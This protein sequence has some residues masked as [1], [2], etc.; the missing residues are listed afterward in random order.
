MPGS[1]NANGSATPGSSADDGTAGAAD[2]SANAPEAPP[3][4][5]APVPARDCPALT[6]SMLLDFGANPSTDPT[7]ALFGDFSTTLSGGTFVYPA[8]PEA[9]ALRS[10]ISSGEWHIAG[11][12]GAVSG[13]GLFFD[14]DQIDA[15]GFDGLSFRISGDVAQDGE[16]TLLVGTA[17]DEV[18]SSWMIASGTD[19][20]ASSNFGRCTPTHDP[21]D[22][23]CT[24]PRVTV[25]VRRGQRRIDVRFSDLGAGSPSAGVNPAEITSITWVLPAP[26]TLADGSAEPYDIDLRIDDIRFLGR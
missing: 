4:A 6:Q 3:A 7:Q 8:L 1:G 24:T 19:P 21:F 25:P 26:T 2:D 9:F 13:F 10:E 20:Q 11:A 16:V 23:S 5:P 22:G 12:V 15:S 18:S 17:S 14:C